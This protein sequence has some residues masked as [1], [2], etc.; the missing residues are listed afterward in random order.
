[1]S[2][3]DPTATTADTTADASHI[4]IVVPEGYTWFF[5]Q[6]ASTV[7]DK[8]LSDELA[9]RDPDAQYTDRYKNGSWDGFHHIYNS[10]H[11]GAPIGLLGRAV[12][13]LEAEGHTVETTVE[14]D[15]SGA[16]IA[17][18]WNFP[19]SLRAYQQEAIEASL[20]KQMGVISIPTGGG[21]TVVA[22]NVI[23]NAEQQ[24][25]VLVHTTN[26][27]YQWADQIESVLGVKPGVIGDGEWSEGPVTVATI[28]S[29]LSSDVG[30]LNG[31]YGVVIFDECHTTSGARK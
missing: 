11:S 21:K 5:V 19:H 16:S 23:H 17:T 27:L 9:W 15:R 4:D 26:L 29:L 13:L 8:L 18:E 2:T 14:G 20:D 30:D 31:H 22:L 6:N 1:M 25:I 12:Q 3:Q 24:A 7:V 28:Q 10:E